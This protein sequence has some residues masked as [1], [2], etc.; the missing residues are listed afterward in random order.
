MDDDAATSITV[1]PSPG[2]YYYNYCRIVSSHRSSTRICHRANHRRRIDER[3]AGYDA[4]RRLGTL[5][6][7]VPGERFAS[8]CVRACVRD[9]GDDD[10]DRSVGRI[11][12]VGPGQGIVVLPGGVD[13]AKVSR[14]GSTR[15]GRGPQLG[16]VCPLPGQPHHV[17]RAPLPRARSRVQ[18]RQSGSALPA[19][20]GVI[21]AG[22]RLGAEAQV[23]GAGA[24]ATDATIRPNS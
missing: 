11:L 16:H 20:R 6:K 8:A 12:V 19:R 24:T 18:D 5:V 2:I 22:R 10:E 3:R 21:V 14:R 15:G 4:P 9:N 1:S 23:G 13:A 7:R 17:R